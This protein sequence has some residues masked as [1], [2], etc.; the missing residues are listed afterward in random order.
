MPKISDWLREATKT[1]KEYDVSSARLDAEIILAHT[2][3]KSR[4]WLHAHADETIEPR[5]HDIA[6]ARVDLRRDHVP[7]AYIIGHKEFYGRRFSVTPSVLVP[8]PESEI[9]IEF[10][11]QYIDTTRLFAQPAQ[12]LIDVGTGS[13]VLGITAKL[14][15]PELD[16]TLTD[17]SRHALSVAKK[18]ARLLGADVTTLSS[19]LLDTYPFSPD[20]IIANLPYVAHDW[21][22][23]EEIA[24]EPDEALFADDG[25]LALIF[26]LIDQADQRLQ[27][28]GILLLEADPRQHT[29]ILER[30]KASGFDVLEHKAFG[31]A[32]QK[33]A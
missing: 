30:S 33:T 1:L 5:F 25:G 14:E 23:G 11:K 18:N 28:S 19:N 29:A 2:L 4:T 32:L 9:L 26:K 21:K 3:R 27:P 22:Q 10:L 12:K 6:D 7:I 24:H 15:L 20:Y 17:T 31:V 13:G 8:R 16:V